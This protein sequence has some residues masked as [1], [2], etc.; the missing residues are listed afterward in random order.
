MRRL[1]MRIRITFCQSYKSMK[2]QFKCHL[3]LLHAIYYSKRIS[4]HSHYNRTAI[5]INSR[6]FSLLFAG[7][8]IW[9]SFI[10]F[11]HINA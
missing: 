11:G 10:G 5:E 1:S 6:L 2:S 3:Y 4:R 7:N 8:I 9:K